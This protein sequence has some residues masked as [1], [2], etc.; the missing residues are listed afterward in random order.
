MRVRRV[1]RAV[2]V[3]RALRLR[4]MAVELCLLCDLKCKGMQGK[5]RVV[6]RAEDCEYKVSGNICVTC[7]AAVHS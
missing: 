4:K 1:L 5:R 2:R 3:P 6:H 7:N